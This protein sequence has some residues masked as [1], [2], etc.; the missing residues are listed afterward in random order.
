DLVERLTELIAAGRRG[1]AVELFQ[2]EVI[3]IPTDVVAQLRHAPFRP[4]LEELAHTLVYEALIIG[5]L[6]LPTDLLA[7]IQTPAL[8]IEGENSAPAMRA[9]ARAVADGLANGRLCT[10]DG[11]THDI[12]PGATAAVLKDFLSMPHQPAT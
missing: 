2:T 3:G 6:T 5:D 7:S 1:D 11:A 8:V 9:A 12:S 10:L 4:A